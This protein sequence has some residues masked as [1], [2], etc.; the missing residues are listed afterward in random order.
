MGLAGMLL[1]LAATACGE[2]STDLAALNDRQLKVAF[3]SDASG[4]ADAVWVT[5]ISHVVRS[6]CLKLDPDTE[7]EVGGRRQ[8]L[9]EP[10]SQGEDDCP[11]EEVAFFLD[12]GEIDRSSPTRIKV[13]DASTTMT[14]S[15]LD[16]FPPRRLD[17]PTRIAG[18]STFELTYDATNDALD[19]NRI[20]DLFTLPGPGPNNV[21]EFPVE[22]AAGSTIVL[23]VPHLYP[24]SMVGAGTLALDVGASLEVE[25]CNGASRCTAEADTHFDVPLTLSRACD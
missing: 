9:G 13:S 22:Q 14:M 8:E 10:S 6:H 1:A 16:L 21:Y 17:A 15:V 24:G 23:S 3:R 12:E 11:D 18:C 25:S 20:Y 19:P 2:P 4:D 5:I 7:F